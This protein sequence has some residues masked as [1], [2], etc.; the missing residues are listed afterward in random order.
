M[1]NKNVFVLTKKFI[2]FALLFIMVI[3]VFSSFFNI[4]EAK[5]F[6]SLSK[7]SSGAYLIASVNDFYYFRNTVND[8]NNGAG[9]TFKLMCDLSFGGAEIK[10]VQNTFSGTFDGNFHQMS[11]YELTEGTE[12]WAGTL[13]KL[14]L[15][16]VLSGATIKNLTL[17]GYV[18]GRSG[19]N[20][21]VTKWIGGF[22]GYAENTNFIFCT[23]HGTIERGLAIGG[24]V[25]RIDSGSIEKCS[26][27][28]DVRAHYSI[29]ENFEYDTYCGG[30]AGIS[31]ITVKNSFNVGNIG[32][33]G[34]DGENAMVLNRYDKVHYYGGITGYCTQTISGCY[35]AG[36]I[37]ESH[38]PESVTIKKDKTEGFLFLKDTYTYQATIVVYQPTFSNINGYLG[39]SSNSMPSVSNCYGT[40]TA[41]RRYEYAVVYFITSPQNSADVG[42]GNLKLESGT[43]SCVVSY[44][45]WYAK[46]SYDSRAPYINYGIY[47]DKECKNKEISGSKNISYIF[48]TNYTAITIS[49]LK[50]SNSG[51]D[52]SVWAYDKYINNGYPHFKD[53]YWKNNP[54]EPS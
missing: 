41:P 23:N 46:C 21:Y 50:S 35:N 1:M 47:S 5:A 19:T 31:Y 34:Y 13:G 53:M 28:G 36:I 44:W 52:S 32:Y 4:M 40:Q 9:K 18:D 10:P 17:R 12:Y 45:K 48:R 39:D 27:Y 22:A 7:D 3:G 25:G 2:S 15:F 51:L 42:Q 37:Y 30:I 11:D 8:G 33:I 16:C 20:K 26:N 43:N 54:V 38:K 24:I 49:K 14:G 6:S 29:R